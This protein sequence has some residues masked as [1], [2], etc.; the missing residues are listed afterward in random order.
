MA[1]Q[2][3]IEAVRTAERAAINAALSHSRSQAV[4]ALALH[5]LVDSVSVAARILDRHLAAL[6]SLAESL[7]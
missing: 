7:R 1:A 3:R 5:P 6:P 2:A 4:E